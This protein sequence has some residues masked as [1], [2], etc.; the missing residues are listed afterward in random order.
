MSNLLR[1]AGLNSRVRESECGNKEALLFSE[2]HYVRGLQC[3]FSSH[4]KKLDAFLCIW[5]RLAAAREAFIGDRNFWVFQL[6]FFFHKVSHVFTLLFVCGLLFGH[7][8]LLVPWGHSRYILFPKRLFP[9]LN[10]NCY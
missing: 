5:L 1:L 2:R 6:F 9:N 4:V 10:S 3:V 7:E 8:R